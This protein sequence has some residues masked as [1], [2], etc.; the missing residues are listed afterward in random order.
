MTDLGAAEGGK[1]KVFSLAWLLDP[2]VQD[3]MGVKVTKHTSYAAQ[4]RFA[5]DQK[6]TE[7][8]AGFRQL[9]QEWN[10]FGLNILYIMLNGDLG[11]QVT[12]AVPQRK[13]NVIQGVYAKNGWMKDNRWV[14]VAEVDQLPNLL[15]PEK[16]Y[17]VNTN[18]LV[19]P[20]SENP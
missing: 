17:I 2:I 13:H 15:N 12:G 9:V 7:D 3:K 16:G 8:G 11:Y 1:R 10:P 6:R 5:V 4:R 18:N 19:G 14:G 20:A